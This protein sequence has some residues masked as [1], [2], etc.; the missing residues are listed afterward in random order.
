MG[1]L[2]SNDTALKASAAHEANVNESVGTRLLSGGS[3]CRQQR[4]LGACRVQRS[5]GPGPNAPGAKPPAR[6]RTHLGRSEI[7]DVRGG[8]V[9][10]FF[11]LLLRARGPVSPAGAVW[12]P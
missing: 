7:V 5:P 8:L 11:D 2:T 1:E 12:A 4:T 3:A 10:G 6:T 9:H